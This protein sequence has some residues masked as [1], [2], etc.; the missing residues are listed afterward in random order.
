M[1]DPRIAILITLDPEHEGGFQNNYDDRANWTSGKVGIGVLVGTNGGI[2]T[3]DM[4][5]IDIRNL[6]LDQKINYYL[7]NYWKQFYSQIN[8]QQVANKL[9]DLGVLFGLGTAVKRF[10]MAL[11]VNA[12]GNFGPLT[13]EA[14]N[15]ASAPRLLVAFKTQMHEHANN[16]AAAN[17][18][19]AADLP[20][21]DR[22]I[23]S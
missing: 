5:G 20:D 11:G 1:A 17:P 13:L 16:V 18:L 22:R 9:F 7:A 3:L 21:W 14:T 15:Q 10:Q 19:E 2:T 4:P 6:T 12:D 8:D 23:D